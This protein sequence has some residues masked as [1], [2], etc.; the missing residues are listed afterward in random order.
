MARFNPAPIFMDRPGIARPGQGSAGILWAAAATVPMMIV[1]VRALFSGGHIYL[2]GDFAL[3]DIQVRAALH[4]SLSVGVHGRYGW[5]HPGPLYL[6][7]ISIVERLTGTNHGAQAQVAT[8]ALIGAGSLFG[9]VLVIGRLGG[10]S[11][12]AV[13]AVVVAGVVIASGSSLGSPWSPNVVVLPVLLLGVL[14]L[15]AARG[16]PVAWA[17]AVLVATLVVQS[18][19]ETTLYAVVAVAGSGML[20]VRR[21]RRGQRGA[22]SAARHPWMV[23]AL[24]VLAVVSWIPPLVNEASPS[25]GNLTAIARFLLHARGRA[26]FVTGAATAASTEVSSIGL[27][28]PAFA[29]ASMATGMLRLAVIV[30]VAATLLLWARRVRD[31]LAFGLAVAFAVGTVTAV[32]SAAGI[33]GPPLLYLMTWSSGVGDIGVLALVL[34]CARSIATHW[35]LNDAVAV[36]HVAG[37]IAVSSF[38]VVSLRASPVARLHNGEV[39]STWKV[40]S[41]RLDADE[42]IHSNGGGQHA[43]GVFVAQH[44]TG[45]VALAG[46]LWGLVDELDLHGFRPRVGRQWLSTVGASYVV[47]G[48]EPVTVGLYPPTAHST[49]LVGFV[50]RTPY[51]DVVI[52]V[53]I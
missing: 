46:P 42:P 44:T 12:A 53:G 23:G 5:H 39:E 50:G 4:G 30:L 11:A 1:A 16:S 36:V 43:E 45:V 51:A 10:T 27:K 14:A 48:S 20:L 38:V 37:A 6:Y 18:D 26:G 29:T 28:A 22:T 40:V 3:M 52:R 25:G 2:N 13:S 33:V 15:A 19:V 7:L 47:S 34:L 35:S 31:E 8:A 49:H 21:R 24:L 41:P 9:T 17:A 32:I